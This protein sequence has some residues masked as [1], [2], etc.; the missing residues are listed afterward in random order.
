MQLDG[1]V[2]ACLVALAVWVVISG[3]DDLFIILAW[4]FTARKKFPWPDEQALEREKER[5]TAVFVPLWREHQVIRQM[6]DH[7]L[8]AIRYGNY[9]VFVGVYPNDEATWRAVEEAAERHPRVHLAEVPHDGPTSKADCLNAIQRSMLEFE[10]RHGV[11]FETIV[12]HDAED[13]IYPDSLRLINWYMR[14]HQMV[15]VPVLALPTGLREVTHGLYC[16]EFAEYQ[17][18]DIPVRT[19]LGGFLPSNGVGTGLDRRVL[20]HLAAGRRGRMFDPACLTEDYETGYRLFRTGCRQIFLPLRFQA[21][22]PAAT[23]EYFPRRLWPAVRQRSRWVAGIVLQ[24]WQNHGW[25]VGFRQAYWFWRDRKGLVGNLL[26]PLV[27]GLFLCGFVDARFRRSM[28]V[29]LLPVYPLTAGIAGIQIA[30]R[31]ATTARVYGWKLAAG[32]PVRMLWGNLVNCLATM[33]ALRQF[34]LARVRRENLAWR[35]TEHVYPVVA[36]ASACDSASD[37]SDSR[38]PLEDLR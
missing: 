9:D 26:A 15:Q 34:L 28:P 24:G 31:M 14:T 30:V 1:G 36:Q 10:A 5:R 11:V 32:V 13:L 25:G 16:D 8:A 37:L 23:R 21:G 20:E 2:I 12:M 19:A 17:S 4:C 6:L 22:V 27:N 33:A 3:L 29:W 35:K 7:N 38:M 18:K